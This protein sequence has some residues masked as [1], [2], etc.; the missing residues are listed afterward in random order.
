MRKHVIAGIWVAVFIFSTCDFGYAAMIT[1]DFHA[2]TTYIEQSYW[3]TQHSDE[4][5][6]LNAAITTEVE[7]TN[8]YLIS[9][10]S[11]F[12]QHAQANVDV[13]PLDYILTI[14]PVTMGGIHRFEVWIDNIAFD[15]MEHITGIS[16]I[17]SGM[18]PAVPVLEFTDNSLHITY[19]SDNYFNFDLEK[20]DTFQ[21]TTVPEPATIMLLGM[22]GLA[23][24]R[25]RHKS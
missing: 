12:R 14:D 18:I 17:S 7:L 24:T 20:S 23:I 3:R 1:G 8:D 15:N 5:E 19:A 2:K 22:G 13:S 11:Y 16:M 25:Y 9:S 10:D 21:I 4:W 6:R